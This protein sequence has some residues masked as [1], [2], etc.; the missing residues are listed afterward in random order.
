MRDRPHKELYCGKLGENAN[1][2]RD[3][4]KRIGDEPT[5]G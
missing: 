3:K 2:P 4:T 5:R 1:G